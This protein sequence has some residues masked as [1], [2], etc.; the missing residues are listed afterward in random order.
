MSKILCAYTKL[1]N[2]N[3]LKPHP[4]NNN[5]HTA[6]QI[7]RLAKI[8]HHNGWTSPITVSTRSRYIT[9]GHAR[10]LAAK[11]LDIQEV[12]VQYVSY[13]DESHE[14]ADLTADNEIARW[15]HLDLDIVKDKIE[16]FENFD[17]ELL[18][19]EKF[20]LEDIGE[21]DIDSP[22]IEDNQEYLIIITC[23]DELD[24]RDLFEEFQ[25]REIECKIMS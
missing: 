5:K 13:R 11:K 3:Q 16:E 25:T 15:A 8:I 12:P 7:E 23:K 21:N 19:I 18:G 4:D 2:V 6:E 17:V 9:K 24:Q 14:Y 1:E 22:P 10:L 20:T